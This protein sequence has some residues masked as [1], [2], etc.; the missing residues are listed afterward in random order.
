M[1]SLLDCYLIHQLLIALE[2]CKV[3]L[4]CILNNIDHEA[5]D[6]PYALVYRS[7][8]EMWAYVSSSAVLLAEL[9]GWWRCKRY[10]TGIT[11]TR[12]N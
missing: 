11:N 3:Y 6:F 4:S 7:L 10:P 2:G 1:S 9:P 12:S 5:L 8:E